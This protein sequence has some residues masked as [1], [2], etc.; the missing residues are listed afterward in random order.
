[1][2]SL[3]GRVLI[4][5]DDVL[6]ALEIESRLRDIG[7]VSFETADTPMMALEQACAHRPDL[8]TAD[9][10]IEGGTGVDA[11]A[12]ITERI[13]AVAVVY[14]TASPELL[15]PDN[16]WPVVAKPVSDFSVARACDLA[17]A[18]FR[19]CRRRSVS[20]GARLAGVDD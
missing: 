15:P 13:G 2:S 6:M 16:P 1:M 20:G 5:E 8:I 14:V 3:R 19:L 12:V 10:H 11:V 17:Q 4:I 9:F 18:L 7:F